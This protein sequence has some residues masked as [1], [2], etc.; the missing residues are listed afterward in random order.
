MTYIGANLG[1]RHFP[2]LGQT[3]RFAPTSA[4]TSIKLF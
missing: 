4:P 3:L 1:V 2:G